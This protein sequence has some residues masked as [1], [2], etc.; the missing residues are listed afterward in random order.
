[1]NGVELEAPTGTNG[2][3]SPKMVHRQ[4]GE[5]SLMAITVSR[6]QYYCFTDLFDN[7]RLKIKFHIYIQ[8]YAVI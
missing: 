8:S 3:V 1:M 6:P 4:Q 7:I 5:C 2:Q